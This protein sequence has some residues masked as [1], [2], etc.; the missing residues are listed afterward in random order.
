MDDYCTYPP[1]RVS[2]DAQVTVDIQG[3]SM[4]DY[5]TTYPPARVSMDVD[6]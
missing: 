3:S 4:D 5:R 6:I 2:L 1:A